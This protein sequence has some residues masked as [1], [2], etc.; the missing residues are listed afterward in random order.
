MIVAPTPFTLISWIIDILFYFFTGSSLF[1]KEAE[2]VAI[3]G[4][5]FAGK[6]TLWKQLKSEMV[7]K[8]YDPTIGADRVSQFSIKYNGKT[9]TIKQSIDF[10]GKDDM[11]RRYGEIIESGTFIYYL[12]DVTTIDKY[13]DETR[14]RLKA[15]CNIIKKKG[16]KDNTGLT[17]VAT[18]FDEYHKNTGG[19]ENEARNKI[20][21][22]LHLKDSKDFNVKDKILVAELTKDKD[23]EQFYKQIME[24]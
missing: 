1:P 10:G 8:G 4:S 2:T 23:I 3:F 12:I 22:C 16:I 20:I 13:K 6:T 21:E 15:I 14:A 18:H 11:V 17:L 19:N 9:K 7:D 24:E 5:P